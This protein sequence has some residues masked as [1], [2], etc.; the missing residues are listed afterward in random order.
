M[1]NVEKWSLFELSFEGPS[2]GNPFTEHHLE[3][4]FQN[5]GEAVHCEGFYDGKGIYKIRFMPS[6][7]GEYHYAVTADFLP[8]TM[9]GSFFST[10]PSE[11]NHGPVRVAYN[12]HFAYEDGSPYYSVGTTCYVWNH[13]SDE[14]IAQTL[15]SLREAGF[16]KLRFCVFPK[17]FDYNLNEP[18]SYPYEGTPM[19][20]GVLTDTNFK[21]YDGDKGGNHFDKTRFNPEH[22]RRIEYCI[23]ELQKAGIEADLIMMHPYDRWGFSCMTHEE[24]ALYWNYCIA[25]FSAYRNVWWSLANEYDILSAK[26]LKDWEF[27]ADLLVQKDPWHHLRSIHHCI[28]QYDYSRPWITHCSLQRHP[29]VTSEYREKYGKPVVLDEMS[30]EGDIPWPWGNITGEEMVRRFWETAVRGGYPGHGETYLR[31]HETNDA[32]SREILWWSHGGKLQGESWKRIRFLYEIMKEIPGHGLKPDKDMF[33]IL[34]ASPEREYT[35]IKSC[36]LVYYGNLQ[37]SQGVVQFDQDT[38]FQVQL[39]DTWNM[40]IREMGVHSGWIKIDMPGRPYMALR[41]IR[42]S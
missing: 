11:N 10:E 42:K 40:T 20:S 1:T 26:T 15:S 25:R 6:F 36:Y 22:F 4:Q 5:T 29:Q 27:Y 35:D 8:E 7:T 14:L 30:Y 28:H 37:P 2:E 19:D 3:G 32:S 12:Y 38:L 16:N 23:A 9:T 41:L 31:H 18:Y 13:Q 39:I 17:H 24:D 34:V 21:D 33:G